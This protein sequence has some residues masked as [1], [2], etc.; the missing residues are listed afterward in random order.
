[1]KDRATCK[2]KILNV[3]SLIY[4]GVMTYEQDVVILSESEQ[5]TRDG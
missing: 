4:A 3:R 5:T 2:N 1:M